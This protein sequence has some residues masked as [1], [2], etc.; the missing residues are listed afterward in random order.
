[1]SFAL[2]IAKVPA[3]N[4]VMICRSKRADQILI[5]EQGKILEYGSRLD[6]AQ[7]PGS[8][9]YHLPQVGLLNK[10]TLGG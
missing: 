8:K 4:Y 5:L 6:L 9:Y 3:S 2:L 10:D 7:D 1:M